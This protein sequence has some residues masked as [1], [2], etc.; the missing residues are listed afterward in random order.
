MGTKWK[1]PVLTQ[2]I[3]L[4]FEYINVKPRFYTRE[5]V[6]QALA[7]YLCGLSSWRV[8]LPHSTL[9]YY[10]RRL[11]Y[12][13]YVVSLSGVYAVDE[14]K[15]L[16]VK[17][18]YYYLWIVR[19]VK[20]RAVSFFMVRSAGSG[21]HV[22]VILAAMRGME[23]LAGKYFKRVDEVVYLHDG[24]SIYNAFTWLNVNHKRVTFGK[25]DYAEQGFR[26]VK[27]RLSPMDKHFPWNSNAK[28]IER[29]FATY[30]LIYNILYCP[31]YLLD[32]GV[33][34]NVNISNE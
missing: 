18:E 29:W 26:S 16:S 12:V 10:F 31:V 32:K 33:I 1:V 30:F 6:A 27:H 23:E 13:R 3:L 28:T 17:G 5:Q 11:S 9:L 15:V 25:R 20:T 19:D 24:A 21:V 7:E 34:I 8:S 4:L 22:L 14:T 2:I